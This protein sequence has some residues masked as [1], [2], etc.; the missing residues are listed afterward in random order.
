M[1]MPVFFTFIS[2][3]QSVKLWQRVG[4]GFLYAGLLWFGFARVQAV[5]LTFDDPS[6]TGFIDTTLTASAAMR[7]KSVNRTGDTVVATG[8]QTDLPVE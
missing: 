3:M 6:I 5:P 2:R 7:V 8:T 4:L 1:D